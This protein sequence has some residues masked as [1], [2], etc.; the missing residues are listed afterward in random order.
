MIIALQFQRQCYLINW[1]YHVFALSKLTNR[2]TTF[3]LSEFLGGVSH[4]LGQY[5]TLLLNLDVD[6]LYSVVNNFFL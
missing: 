4:F 5:L 1:A 6:H 2:K 3:N